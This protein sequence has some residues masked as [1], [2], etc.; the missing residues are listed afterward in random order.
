MEWCTYVV[1]STVARECNLVWTI[2]QEGVKIQQKLVVIELAYQVQVQVPQMI[3]N[4]LKR[5]RKS[6]QV[7]HHFLMNMYTPIV[8]VTFMWC[9][10]IH[11]CLN[12]YGVWYLEMYIGVAKSGDMRVWI[13]RFSWIFQ[14]WYSVQL[15]S[16]VVSSNDPQVTGTN[17]QT[18]LY[19]QSW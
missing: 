14:V 16:M 5:R 10:Y 17:F 4:G 15:I 3:R 9:N 8:W 2:R 12:T 7:M 13:S 1:P 11:N 19:Y 6:C 18:K